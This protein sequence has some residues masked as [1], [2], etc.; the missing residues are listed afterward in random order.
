MTTIKDVARE[1]GFSIA[2]VSRVLNNVGP[3]DEETRKQVKAA[4]RRLKYVP[5]SLGRGL[6]I[7]RTDAIG[8]LLPDLF[9]EFFSEVIRGA[10][11]TA[12]KL[13]YHLLVSSS[14]SGREEIAGALKT[15]R[16][17]VDGL[18]IMSPDIDAQTLD[19]NLPHG[20]PVVLV[21]CPMDNTSFDSLNIDNYGGAVEMV[22]H[23]IGH[24]HERIA[25]ITGTP[26]NFDAGDRLRGFRDAMAEGGRPVDEGMVIAGEFS[27]TSGYE[28][29]LALLGRAVR[30]T[31]IFA[32]NDSMA[33][34]ALSALR[35]QE[36]RIPEEIALAG[37]DDT[38]IG[39]FLSPALTSVRVDIYN[40]G[41]LAVEHLIRAVREKSRLARHQTVLTTTLSL[42][43][44]CGCS[45]R[46]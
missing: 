19:Q 30:P 23:L 22:R 27:E 35:E 32:S 16:G 21:N 36:V 40:L 8:L 31:A 37:F 34:G 33:I 17:R 7:R 26:G 9:G 18:V 3:V 43:E 20:H 38:P 39:A 6:S 29:T 11:R 14:H 4:A 24:G 42:R 2:T 15:M 46:K 25:I 13:G 45:A 28:A 10:D 1:A 5:N 12:Q 41:V 44:S